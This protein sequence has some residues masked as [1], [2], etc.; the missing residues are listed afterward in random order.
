MN[1]VRV[2]FGGDVCAFLGLK[3]LQN[4]LPSLIKNESID[5]VF[6]NGENVLDGS[7]VDEKTSQLFFQA[8]CDVIT[9]G[10]HTLEKFDIRATFG[11]DANVLRPANM[12]FVRG[13][14]V[15]K[16][17]KN[18]VPYVVINIMGRENMRVIDCPFQTADLILADIAADSEY[19]DAIVLVDF[20]AESTEE[21]EAFGFYLDGRVSFVT[22]T[23]TH[24]QTADEKILPEGTSYIT[25]AGMIGPLG[26][27]IGGEPEPALLKALTQVPCQHKWAENGK[28]VFCGVIVEIDT[29]TKKTISIERIA[30]TFEF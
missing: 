21:K 2:L 18:G 6:V 13:N 12:A 7:G 28:A 10:N 4:T 5:F 29:E 17:K 1:T 15:C 24:T 20:H 30:K 27:V 14:G 16:I 3:M 19:A 8:G 25:D 22:C 26:G 11:L 23:H 9:G